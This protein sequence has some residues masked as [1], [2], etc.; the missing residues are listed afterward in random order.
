MNRN[1]FVGN[2]LLSVG[3][4]LLFAPFTLLTH[5]ALS[6]KSKITAEKLLSVQ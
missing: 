6:A 2:L 4:M 1:F 3:K 5:E